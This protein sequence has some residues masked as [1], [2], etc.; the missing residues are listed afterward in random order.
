MRRRRFVE[1]LLAAPLA[2]SFELVP[3]ALAQQPGSRG[4]N[5]AAGDLAFAVGDDAAETTVRFFSERQYAT[6]E[7][8]SEMLMPSDSNLPGAREARA[9]EFLDFLLSV[10]PHERK[11]LYLVGLDTLEYQSRVR[12]ARSF[13]D[14]NNRQADALLAGLRAP[15]TQEPPDRLTEFLRAAKHDVR[16]AT[17]NSRE[18]SAAAERP[19][20]G[21]YWLPVE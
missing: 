1:A 16:T 8:L 19:S 17:M 10:S 15:W 14:A 18:Y 21:R 9:P 13:A 4:Q 2:A 20:M 11:Q 7:R 6:L 12:F 5:G 3:A